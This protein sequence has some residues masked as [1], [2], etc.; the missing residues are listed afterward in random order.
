MKTEKPMNKPIDGGQAFPTFVP[1]VD[2]AGKHTYF[3]G[4][5]LRDWFAGQALTGTLSTKEAHLTIANGTVTPAEIA[6]SS[7]E[8]ADLMLKAREAK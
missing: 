1:V 8:W 3:G 7:Y 2:N 4:M 6:G 5:S